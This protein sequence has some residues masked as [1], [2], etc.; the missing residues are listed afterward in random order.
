MYYRAR[1]YDPTTGRFIS[2]DAARLLG[3]SLN[4]YKYV[5]NNPLRL[6]D[7]LGLVT[8]DVTLNFNLQFGPIT[9][10]GSA[11]VALDNHGNVG[12]TLAPGGGVGVG[13]TSSVTL[14]LQASNAKTI[15]DLKGPFNNLSAGAGAGIDASV[16][17]FYGTSD[18]GPVAGVGVGLG[19]GVGA[20]ASAT[21]TTTTVKPINGCSCQ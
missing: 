15:C 17:S 9:I 16:D 8:L 18:H 3:G 7:P 12:I 11:G 21:V 6:K 10:V 19:V 1:Y 13:L 20:G 4:F 5:R 14:S 2:E